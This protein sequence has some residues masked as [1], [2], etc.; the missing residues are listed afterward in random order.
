M[1]D[2]RMIS[3]L[4]ST[5]VDQLRHLVHPKTGRI[6]TSYNQTVAATGRLSSSNPN[7]Q[8][9]PIRRE[10]GRRIRQ[11]FTAPKGCQILSADYSQIEIRL[12]AAFSKDK[13]LIEA[14]KK[15][16]DVHRM[17]AEK[18]F[19]KK[20]NQITDKLRAMA[21]TVN[22]GVIYGQ[23]P[24]GLSNLL[25]I[26]MADAKDYIEQFYQKYPSVK[27]YREKVLEEAR[28]KEEVRTW[29][30]RKRFVGEINSKNGGLRAN[31]ERTAFNTVFQ[32]SA[33]DLIKVAMIKIDQ[34]LQAE[35]KK[36]KMIMQVHDELIFEVPDNEL[37]TVSTLVKEEMEGAIA[38]SVPLK[39]DIGIGKSW[40]E[41]H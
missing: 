13:H 40:D 39:V 29:K 28:Q 6:H 37:T 30:G 1:L 36:S 21:K 22:F 34:R 16:E 33:A 32:G 20:G 12:L 24:F 35:K 14:F 19:A 10:E 9:I 3:K 5:Y 25:G 38:C 41:A 26:S 7:L 27:K 23:G 8:N 18:L 31:A 11:A 15:G 4:N 2:H 17:T